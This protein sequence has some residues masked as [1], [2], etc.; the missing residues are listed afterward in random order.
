MATTPTHVS[1]LKKLRGDCETTALDTDPA[2]TIAAMDKRYKLTSTRVALTALRK[3]YPNCKAFLDEM[4]ARYLTYRKLDENQEPSEAQMDNFVSWENIIQ[5]RDL[6]KD[7][8]TPEQRL[9]MG[10]YTRIPPVRADYTPMIVVRRRPATLKDGFNYLVWTAQPYFIFHSYKTHNRYGD[11][12]VKIPDDLKTDIHEYLVGRGDY[13][14][15]FEVGGEPWS[16]AR[17]ADSVRAIFQKFHG[18]NTGINLF[19]HA[20]LTKY[21]AGQKA[22]SE[23]N[24]LATAMMHSPMLGQAYRFVGFEGEL[25]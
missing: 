23:M 8:M 6:Y 7:E 11:L 22:L 18:L 5:F 4:K 17:L 14:Y 15:L 25:F 21:Y 1:M 19:R 12:T 2:K 9:L 24:K 16:P 3:E 20:Y 13:T 10:L